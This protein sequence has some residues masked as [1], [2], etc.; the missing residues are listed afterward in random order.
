MTI[1]AITYIVH[2]RA[3][4]KG[5]DVEI[6]LRRSDPDTHYIFLALAGATSD[7]TAPLPCHVA[8]CGIT[9]TSVQ[10]AA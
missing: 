9:V 1:T 2:D 10:G 6:T 7:F 4:I 8:E 3:G 5:N